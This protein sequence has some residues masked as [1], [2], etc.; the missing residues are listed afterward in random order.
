MY[1]LFIVIV[2]KNGGENTPVKKR[3]IHF[4]LIITLCNILEGGFVDS[5]PFDSGARGSE[6]KPCEH[7]PPQGP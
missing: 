6:G 5:F 2:L 1:P 4:H 7:T 3:P